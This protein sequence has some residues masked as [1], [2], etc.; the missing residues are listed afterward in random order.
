MGELTDDFLRL[1]AALVAGGVIGLERESQD[2]PAGFRT[3]ILICVGAALF[4]LVSERAASV[5]G[6]DPQR[7]AAQ[8]VTGV[9][10]LGAGAIIQHRGAVS[11]L[12]T[13]ATI[14]VVASI[15]TAFGCGRFVLGVM[16]TVLTAATLF[17]LGLVEA[18]VAGFR[19]RTTLELELE[20]T[21]GAVDGVEALVESCGAHRVSSSISKSPQGLGLVV[22]V[23]GTS[24]QLAELH[25]RLMALPSVRT[26][27]RR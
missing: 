26:L 4:A 16:G 17:G 10:F 8:I 20:P 3:N 21:D 12:T 25:R 27:R 15:G 24:E 13:A 23:A 9:G 18:R 5:S 14:W 1:L 7:I 2:K 22:V 19:T 6:G 11:G